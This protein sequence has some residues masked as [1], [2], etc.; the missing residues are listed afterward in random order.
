M[1]L[2]VMTPHQAVVSDIYL[3]DEDADVGL[4]LGNYIHNIQRI[5]I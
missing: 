2:I 3:T 1:T 5:Y 4:S